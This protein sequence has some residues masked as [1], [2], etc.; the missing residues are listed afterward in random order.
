[1]FATVSVLVLVLNLFSSTFSQD[2]FVLPLI[3]SS[4]AYQLSK[5][6]NMDNY[7]LSLT[8]QLRPGGVSPF[9]SDIIHF[10]AFKSML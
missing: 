3:L 1:M 4:F 2:L 8:R 5:E 7:V 6:N 10:L 9:M